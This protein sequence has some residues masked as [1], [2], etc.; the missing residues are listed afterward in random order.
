MSTPQRQKRH[1]PKI[2]YSRELP[3]GGYVTIH[4]EL[5]DD[6]SYHG[7][8]SVERRADVPRRDGTAIPVIA[9]AQ[10]PTAESVYTSLHQIAADNVAVA[11]A[12]RRWESEHPKESG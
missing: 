11:H 1:S 7:W 10:G 4:T 6:A 9:E 2:Q 8:I 3:G 12:I 5:A